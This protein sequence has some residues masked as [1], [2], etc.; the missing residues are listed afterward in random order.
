[1]VEDLINP[2]HLSHWGSRSETASRPRPNPAPSLSLCNLL[3][4]LLLLQVNLRDVLLAACLIDCSWSRR[5]SRNCWNRCQIVQHF[6]LLSFFCFF[7]LGFLFIFLCV[8]RLLCCSCLLFSFVVV[9]WLCGF[10]FLWNIFRLAPDDGN[11]FVDFTTRECISISGLSIC[12]SCK[13]KGERKWVGKSES[14]REGDSKGTRH[15]E[16]QVLSN[17][18]GKLDMCHVWPRYMPGEPSSLLGWVK[19][20]RY[21]LLYLYM[22][23][24]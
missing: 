12:K 23:E 5:R 8:L 2:R 3:L 7:F 24:I 17:H 9:H 4:S 16:L 1:M 20:K 14:D 13:R 21:S 22:I 6:V 10:E 18:M 19:V 11:S 15:K